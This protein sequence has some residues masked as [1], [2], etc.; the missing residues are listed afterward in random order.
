MKSEKMKVTS[1][2]AKRDRHGKPY[3]DRKE[4]IKEYELKAADRH[5]FLCNM[6]G[7]STYPKCMEW[8]PSG[9]DK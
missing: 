3:I 1:L 8:C 9:K 7:F 5:C 4:V 2:E 6:C